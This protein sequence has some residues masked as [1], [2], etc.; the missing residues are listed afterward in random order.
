MTEQG[1]WS[2]SLERTWWQAWLL[3][4]EPACWTLDPLG[5]W[6]ANQGLWHLPWVPRHHLDPCCHLCLVQG[7]SFPHPSPSFLPS[8]INRGCVQCTVTPWRH[9]QLLGTSS[10]QINRGFVQCTVTPWR[11]PQ[12]LGTSASEINRGFVHSTGTPGGLLL[13]GLLR[14][15][16]TAGTRTSGGIHSLLVLHILR[17]NT[18]G[19]R[20]SPCSGA[21]TPDNL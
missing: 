4:S 6:A 12:L 2:C 18:R 1:Y 10:S 17:Q 14:H 20:F 19:Q 7:P 3:P 13:L 15:R 5:R 9:P 16:S 21:E 11:P 8:K